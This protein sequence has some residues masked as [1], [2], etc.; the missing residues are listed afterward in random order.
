MKIIWFIAFIIIF[1]VG[2]DA[3]GQTRTQ[4][5]RALDIGSSRLFRDAR[6]E[7]E[8]NRRG[9]LCRLRLFPRAEEKKDSN[10][11]RVSGET[12]YQIL[13]LLSPENERGN[14]TTN[15]GMGLFLGQ[16]YGIS[17]EFDN[18]L[19]AAAGTIRRSSGVR[20]FELDKNPMF[21]AAEQITFTWKKRQCS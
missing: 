18:V 17:Y 13:E 16:G 12:T 2:S 14:R 21:P 9:Q 15:W 19:V 1:G 6:L 10:F 20:I 8:F 5:E 4:F 3:F 11:V 7:P